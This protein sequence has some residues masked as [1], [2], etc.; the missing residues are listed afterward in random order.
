ML[1]AT[2]AG[3]AQPPLSGVGG[4][5]VADHRVDAGFGVERTMGPVVSAGMTLDLRS[6]LWLVLHA[7]A[8]SLSARSSGAID[9]DF[10]EVALTAQWRATPWLAAEAGAA[11][12]SYSSVV[13]RQR[14]ILVRTGGEIRVPLA[15]GGS[16]GVF[17]LGYLPVV[18]VSGLETPRLAFAAGAGMEYRRG[19]AC[20]RAAY[21]L[22]RYDF[23]LAGAT[24]RL[25]QL[26]AVSVSLSLRLRRAS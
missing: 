5:T 2:A 22:E 16:V 12:R 19:R 23:P 11:A 18:A 8:G 6:R 20:L 25:E 14:W 24:R 1:V 10:G 9:R 13:G 26:S 15:W 3:E 17:R 4:L 7:R 21:E